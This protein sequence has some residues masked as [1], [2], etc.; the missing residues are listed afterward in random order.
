MTKIK[1]SKTIHNSFWFT[2]I[3][4]A[5]VMPL[6]ASLKLLSE[7]NKIQAIYNFDTFGKH[8]NLSLWLQR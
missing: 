3:E 8:H 6:L 4:F 1:Y 7:D 5:A 2:L